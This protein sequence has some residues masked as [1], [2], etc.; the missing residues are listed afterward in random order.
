MFITPQEMEAARFLS[1]KYEP[2]VLFYALVVQAAARQ[3]SAMQ[4]KLE[5]WQS[6][7]PILPPILGALTQAVRNDVLE[8]F[9]TEFLVSV[10]Q[11]TAH[12]ES[13]ISQLL[14]VIIADYIAAHPELT[15][16]TYVMK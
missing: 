14:D 3:H 2:K 15:K 5:I 4:K 16:L 13:A 10:Q 8:T 6:G 7:E 9:P 11:D 12:D 1:S